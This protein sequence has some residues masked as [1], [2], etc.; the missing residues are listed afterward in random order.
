MIKV[1]I[2]GGIGSGKSTVCKMFEKHFN[3]P[4]YYA[5]SRAKYLMNHSKSLKKEIKELF[6]FE[7]YHRNGK[8]NRAHLAS[9]IFTD[10]SVLLKLNKLV[11]P[12]VYADAEHWFSSLK[13]IPYA[14]K[15]SA[16]LFESKGDKY[17][18]KVIV[19]HCDNEERIRRVMKR[20]D[21]NRKEVLNR[22][23][24][25]MPQKDKM[26]KA[27]YLIDNYSRAELK[28]QVNKIHQNLISLEGK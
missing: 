18:D 8:L 16:L 14:L 15:E 22:I 19:V 28:T 23:N 5:D 25:Q 24:K 13:N 17:V 9:I 2:T 1:A 4:V 6:G 7:V 12:A 3:I 21:L 26:K 10:K 11:H 20:D 27:D